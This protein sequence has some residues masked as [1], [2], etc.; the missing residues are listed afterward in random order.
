MN[1]RVRAAQEQDL[2]S[3]YDLARQFSLLSLPAD[4]KTIL[5]RIENSEQSFSGSLDK[6]KSKY[7]FVV[8]DIENGVIAGCSQINAKHGTEKNPTYSFKILKKERFSSDLGIGFIHQILRLKICTDGPTEIG[9]LVV[10]KNFRRRPEKVGRLV[11]LMRFMYIGM[12]PQNFQS[13]LFQDPFPYH[14]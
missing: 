3:I 12:N 13:E 1:F 7:M 4:K 6:E 8:E 10:G 5:E 14:Q 9:G 11:S 2:E